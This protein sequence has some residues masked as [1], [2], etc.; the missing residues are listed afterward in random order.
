[1]LQGFKDFL[2]RGNIVDLAVA[3]VIGT[4]FT[5]LVSTFTAAIIEPIINAFGGAN[6]DGL[7]YQL[8]EKN[9]ATVID[10]A[11]VI[12]AIIT[13][14]IT[15]AV[16]YFIFVVPSKKLMERLATGQEEEPEGPSEDIL[17]L[18][19][20]RDALGGSATQRGPAPGVDP[21]A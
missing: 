20:I 9:D 5:A 12:N 7:S 1:M 21:T 19:E 8:I 11:A 6:V 13:F 2:L 10:F 3:V 18:R 16:V 17:L 4:A 14:L 15:A